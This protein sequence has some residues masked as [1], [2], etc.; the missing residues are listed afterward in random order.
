M[1]AFGTEFRLIN[2]ALF[3]HWIATVGPKMEAAANEAA[4]EIGKRAVSEIQS[5]LYPGHGYR[6][7]NLYRSYHYK[8]TGSG[9]QVGLEVGSNCEYAPYVEYRWG[10][11]VS[12]FRPAM[13]VV[14]KE[15]PKII[16]DRLGAVLQ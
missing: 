10:G 15:A 6:T 9:A 14:E 7:G 8:V 1:A 12:H 16:R 4:D 11:K 5:R 2:D 3:F 13:A